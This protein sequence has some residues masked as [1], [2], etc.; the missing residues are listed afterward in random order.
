LRILP[1]DLA[2]FVAA[3]IAAAGFRK[4]DDV[5]HGMVA[6]ELGLVVLG[7]RYRCFCA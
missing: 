5:W 4:I 6:F 7:F 2:L 1:G 3:Q